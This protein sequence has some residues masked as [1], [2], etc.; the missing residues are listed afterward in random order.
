MN[1]SSFVL[2]SPTLG[3]PLSNV[4]LLELCFRGLILLRTAREGA[5]SPFTRSRGQPRLPLR[6]TTGTTARL[7][8][9]NA[10]PKRR[11]PS[12]ARSR[13]HTQRTSPVYRQLAASKFRVFPIQFSTV[14]LN[15]PTHTPPRMERRVLAVSST[16]RT[17]AVDRHGSLHGDSRA[18]RGVHHH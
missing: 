16:T 6:T 11:A 10:R 14:K 8:S 3:V 5:V 9:T 7:N 17:Q 12:A 4:S 2:Y 13:Q 1:A 15:P 18:V